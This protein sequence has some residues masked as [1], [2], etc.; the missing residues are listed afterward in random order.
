MICVRQTDLKALIAYSSVGHMRIVAAAIF[1][2]TSWGLKGALML[3]VAHGLVS[4][5]LFSL[6][7]TVY[8]RRGTRTLAIIRGLKVL[9]PLRTI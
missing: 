2:E 1:T 4:S 5:A 6:A 3:M 7:K 9:L 8:E